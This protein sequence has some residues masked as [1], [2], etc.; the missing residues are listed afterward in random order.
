MRVPPNYG[1]DYVKGFDAM[2]PALAAE[3]RLPLIPFLLEGVAGKPELNQEDGIHPN[4]E[5]QKILAENV[6]KVLSMALRSE[7]VP[8]SAAPAPAGPATTSPSSS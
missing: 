1:D 6:W 3:F 4:A 5:G 7:D 8:A 2:F